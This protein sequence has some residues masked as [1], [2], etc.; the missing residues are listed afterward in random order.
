MVPGVKILGLKVNF[1]ALEEVKML[2]SCLR[3]FPNVEILHI[4][5]TPS[6][7]STLS[8]SVIL[9]QKASWLFSCVIHL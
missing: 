5:V 6:I 8:C 4:E 9:Q 1:G 3:C 2:V 7:Y